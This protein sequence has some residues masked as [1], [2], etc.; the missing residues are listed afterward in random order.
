MVCCSSNK[1]RFSIL[2][3][4]F[5]S[6][7]T[8]A[9]S[10]IYAEGA[11]IY[12]LHQ[13]LS[14][15]KLFCL[16]F[17]PQIVFFKALI[18]DIHNMQPIFPCELAEDDRVHLDGLHV[19]AAHQESHILKAL[20][21]VGEDVL[22]HILPGIATLL[23]NAGGFLCDHPVRLAVLV[24]VDEVIHHIRQG[25]SAA[26][27]HVLIDRLEQHRLVGIAHIHRFDKFHKF[28]RHILRRDE[29]PAV[30]LGNVSDTFFAEIVEHLLVAKRDRK[31]RLDFSILDITIY[32]F[33]LHIYHP[34]KLNLRDHIL[35][36]VLPVEKVNDLIV[37]HI[38]WHIQP[39]LRLFALKQ[40]SHFHHRRVVLLCSCN[41]AFEH[42]NGALH[43]CRELCAKI[44][45]FLNECLNIG[46]GQ[47]N[48]IAALPGACIQS[49]VT[50]SAPRA[51]MQQV[52]EKSRP[53]FVKDF[54]HGLPCVDGCCRRIS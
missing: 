13:Y 31:I 5:R 29:I 48:Q 35:D 12:I 38:D 24:K 51:A 23:I 14:N 45:V 7:Y 44:T 11:F 33:G 22:L 21:G 15:K 27:I 42:L 4:S 40:H 18:A 32:R 36:V 41:V 2:V 6:S 43:Q 8:M 26:G 9:F 54:P 37:G 52:L 10:L 39:C 20:E 49:M 34:N 28:V 50:Q 46:L 3:R 30:L 16:L 25:N 1:D 47:Q 53:C 17:Y 19:L